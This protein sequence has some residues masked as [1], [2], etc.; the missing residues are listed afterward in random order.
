MNTPDMLFYSRECPMCKNLF[1]LLKSENMLTRFKL[2]CVDNILDKIPKTIT[3]VPTLILSNI[4]Q[5][6]VAEQIFL[7]IKASKEIKSEKKIENI[8]DPYIDH[9]NSYTHVTKDNDKTNLYELDGKNDFIFTPPEKSKINDTEQIKYVNNVNNIRNE[10]TS[11]F[12]KIF[13]NDQLSAVKKYED[14]IKNIT[15]T[16][17]F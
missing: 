17:K 13:L 16:R 11:Y 12:S 6:L 3:K 15:K 8:Y 14:E 7:W 5:P 10:Q 4:N 1:L 9:N 2:I